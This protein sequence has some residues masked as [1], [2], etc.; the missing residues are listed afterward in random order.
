MPYL[1]FAL[2]NVI[3]KWLQSW[4]AVFIHYLTVNTVLFDCGPFKQE[5]KEEYKEL[6][7]F[8]KSQ[9]IIIKK[10]LTQL[11]IIVP[12]PGHH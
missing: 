2:E 11:L 12:L 5:K 10:Q 8:Q 7:A 6:E 3:F 4:A 9:K 1:V